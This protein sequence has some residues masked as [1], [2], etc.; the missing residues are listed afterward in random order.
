M[1]LFKAML[2]IHQ[3]KLK[4]LLQRKGLKRIPPKVEDTLELLTALDLQVNDQ[5][6]S[7]EPPNKRVRRI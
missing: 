4:E 5:K 1:L 2:P 7:N 3:A 6:H